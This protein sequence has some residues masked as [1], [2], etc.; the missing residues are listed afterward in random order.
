M[1]LQ[2]AL[3]SVSARTSKVCLS[4]GSSSSP[5]LSSSALRS[6]ENMVVRFGIWL[7][8]TCNQSGTQ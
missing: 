4:G 2:M 1:A 7:L 3:G 8:R 6:A 5:T